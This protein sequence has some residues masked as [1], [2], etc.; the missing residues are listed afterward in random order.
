MTPTFGFPPV[1]AT[2]ARALAL[3]AFLALL[4]CGGQDTPCGSSDDC[5]SATPEPTPDPSAPVH[6]FFWITSL[7]LADAGQGLDLDGDGEIDNGLPAMLEVVSEVVS[8]GV[9]DALCGDEGCSDDQ[10]DLLA[11]AQSFIEIAFSL[12]TLSWAITTPI[13]TG[14]ATYLA[15]MDGDSLAGD[16]S[17][18]WYLSK[19]PETD[20]SRCV[21][22][23]TLDEQGAGRFGTCDLHLVTD[24]YGGADG[25]FEITLDL[26]FS[27]A[28][29]EISS[30]AWKG[31]QFT[32]GAVV[33]APVMLA[34]IE[35]VLTVMNDV[36]DAGIPIEIAMLA[37]EAT[38]P[39][40]ADYDTDGDGSNDAFSI[41]VIGHVAD[42]PAH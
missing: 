3:G 24:S 42:M 23:G 11:Q 5:S 6:T 25:S 12:P 15:A 37:I 10:A 16:L 28:Q 38:L 30:F 13:Q 26:I 36:M 33:T 4:G 20:S 2:A 39:N 19:T 1:P 29:I 32:G 9:E 41:G 40:Y 34:A 18:T 8:A 17:F 27:E 21:M 35:Q 22:T 31:F 14:E 7:D